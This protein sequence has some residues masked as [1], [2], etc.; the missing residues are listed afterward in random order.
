M[1]TRA[2]YVAVG[3]FTLVA[4]VTA[5]VLVYWFGRF[6]GRDQLVPLDI[7]I[8]GS[9]SGLGEGSLVTFN[10]I[11][12]GRVSGLRLDATDPRFVIVNTRINRNT[13]VRADTRASI[14]IRGLSGGAY[15]Q[16]EGGSPQELR[17]LQSEGEGSTDPTTQA[18]VISGDPAALA[19]LVAR[20]NDLANTTE[21]VMETVE[22]FVTTNSSTVTRTLS[23]AETFSKALA[24]NSG[25]VDEF[26]TSAGKVAESLS[27]LSQKLDGSVSRLEAVLNAVDPASVKATVESVQNSAAQIETLTKGANETLSRIDET[28]TAVDAESIKATVESIGTAAKRV[29]AMSGSLSASVAALTAAIQP[30]KVGATVDNLEKL[31]QDAQKLVQAIDAET[32]KSTIESVNRSAATI[33]TVTKSAETVLADAGKAVKAVDPAAVKATVG[34]I[35]ATAA[36]IEALSDNLTTSLNSVVA[37][38]QPDKI[39]SV[40][41]NADRLTRDAQQVVASI[42]GEKLRK[43]VDDISQTA[44]NARGLLEGIDQDAVRSLVAEMGNASKSVATILQSLDAARIDRAVD[45]IA[46]AASGAQKVVS[47][48]SKIT[49]K[50]SDKGDDVDRI[51]ADATELSGRL[52]EASKRVDGLLD[53]VDSLLG[54][55]QTDG[56]VADARSTLATF[57][58]AARSLEVQVSAISGNIDRFTKRGLGDTQGLIKDARQSLNALN[59]VIRNIESNPSSLIT[60]SGGSRVRETRGGRPRR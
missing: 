4:L 52:N 9:V 43:T 35:N 8:Q 11:D 32:V 30:Q 42:D 27:S 57:R 56:L 5:F 25:G 28:V 60:G 41:D 16:L 26:L 10:G 17:L 21:R 3:I 54:S 38:L 15:I 24:D 12:V 37:A 33:E 22:A 53:K 50:F 36:R 51:F 59:R 13:P 2:N 6:D 40:V 18:P 46:D 49:E 45:N 7:R 55:G 29:E 20:V 39:R 23:N 14:G 47:D 31:T 58:Q 34:N 48:V 44:S 1:E 19:D